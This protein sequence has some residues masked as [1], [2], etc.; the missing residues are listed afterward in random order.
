MSALA[1]TEHEHLFTTNQQVATRVMLRV[2]SCVSSQI[3]LGYSV[4]LGV[5]IVRL[6]DGDGGPELTP[7]TA[8]RVTV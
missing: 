4:R 5:E 8:S 7:V 3:P 6:G 1:I 2:A